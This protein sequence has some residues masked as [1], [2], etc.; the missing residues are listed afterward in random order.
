[1]IQPSWNVT[2]LVAARAPRATEMTAP[3]AAMPASSAAERPS[4]WR[5]VSSWLAGVRLIYPPWGTARPPGRGTARPRSATLAGFPGESKRARLRCHDE[6]E[7]GLRRAARR[8]R[9]AR[10]Q[11]H[12]GSRRSVPPARGEARS[13]EARR[14]PAPHAVR[15]RA[16]GR[17]LPRPERSRVPAHSDLRSGG[18]RGS[19]APRQRVENVLDSLESWRARAARRRNKRKLRLAPDRRGRGRRASGRSRAP[20]ELPHARYHADRPA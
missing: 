17:A 7:R 14:A 9:D 16:P 3:P 1:M 11:P 15:P 6:L 5:R 13:R 10:R 8:L 4:M 2:S 18:R 12:L 20:Q 19:A